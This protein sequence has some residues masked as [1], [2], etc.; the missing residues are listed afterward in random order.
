MF[1]KFKHKEVVALQKEL[2]ET[3]KDLRNAIALGLLSGEKLIAKNNKHVEEILLLKEENK[4]LKEDKDSL[5]KRWNQ[6]CTHSIIY[7]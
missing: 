1:D 3:Q 7:D 6:G 2:K 4:K 5:L